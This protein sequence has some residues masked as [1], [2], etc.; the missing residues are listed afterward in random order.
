MAERKLSRRQAL[1]V[2]AAGLAAGAALQFGI[3]G[4][5]RAQTPIAGSALPNG[6]YAHNVDI[7]GYSDLDHRPAFKMAIRE[8]AGRWYLYAGHFWHRGWSIIDVTDP[9][10]PHVAKFVEYP[11]ANT[12]T[13]QVDLS[14]D[15]MITAL[16]KPFANFGGNPNAPF[17]EGVLIWISPTRSTRASSATTARA[18]SALTGTSTP[19]GPICISLPACQGTK[20]T[21]TSSLISQIAPARARPDAGGCPVNMKSAVKWRHSPPSLPTTDSG[22]C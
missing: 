20:A 22:H 1:N 2:S 19:A 3:F 13:L 21:F 12:W 8:V 18:A 7:V 6:A 4:K 11:G 5:A 17:G 15:T 9:S 16:E 14:G 10:R